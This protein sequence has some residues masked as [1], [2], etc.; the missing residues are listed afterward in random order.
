M[1]GVLES[2]ALKVRG[3]I[4]FRFFAEFSLVCVSWRYQ[5]ITRFENWP[6][7][8]MSVI[9]ILRQSAVRSVV[10]QRLTKLTGME[11]VSL[12]A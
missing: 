5:A 11:L 12:F 3:R 9:A 1:R 10:L 8:S 4:S 7:G 6:G 2:L